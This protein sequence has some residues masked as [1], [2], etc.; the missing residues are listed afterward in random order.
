MSKTS[1]LDESLIF[2]YP[3][4]PLFTKWLKIMIITTCEAEYVDKYGDTVY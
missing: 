3:Q 1:V 2:L 4:W